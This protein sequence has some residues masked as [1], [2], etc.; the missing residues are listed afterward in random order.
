MARILIIDDDMD[1]RALMKER[2]EYV[3]HETEEAEDGLTGI[4]KI[5]S[6]KPEVILL[7]LIMPNADGYDVLKAMH[8]DADTGMLQ[9]R[10]I[11]LSGQDDFE[12]VATALR[13]GACD[14]LDKPCSFD[15]LLNAVHTATMRAADQAPPAPATNYQLSR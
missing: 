10:A 13:L 8:T 2:L 6:Y 3:G 9:I 14:Y 5:A 11:V 1:S 15:E 12:A 4:K 7:D